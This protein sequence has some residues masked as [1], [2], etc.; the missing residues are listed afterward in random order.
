MLTACEPEVRG[1]VAAP[2]RERMCFETEA[3]RREVDFY[4][5]APDAAARRRMEGAFAALDARIKTL[6]TAA[7]TQSGTEREE[8]ERRIA[9]LKR[10][11]ELHW[12]RAQ[13]LLAETTP[14]RRAEPVGERRGRNATAADGS[15]RRSGRSRG[16]AVRRMAP[17]QP[18]REGLFQ[19]LFR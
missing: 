14:V 9:D 12:A 6:E 13:T 5:D 16:A 10:R 11:R 7:Q 2:P 15:T 18:V 3:V 17:V 8:S 1:P 19:R 4:K